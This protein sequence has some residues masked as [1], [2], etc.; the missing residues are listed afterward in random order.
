MVSQQAQLQRGGRLPP[1]PAPGPLPMRAGLGL[2]ERY[3]NAAIQEMLQRGPSAGPTGPMPGQGGEM[4]ILAFEPIGESDDEVI[5]GGELDVPHPDSHEFL[6]GRVGYDDWSLKAEAGVARAKGNGWS[7]LNAEGQAGGWY[8][9]DGHWNLGAHGHLGV[10]EGEHDFWGEP[11]E[12]DGYLRVRGGLLSMGAGQRTGTD[13][14]EGLIGFDAGYL[15]AGVGT[16][17]DAD[18]ANDLDIDLTASL[19][20]L[21]TG[22]GLNFTDRDDDGVQEL[23]L[24]LGLDIGAGVGLSVTS[25]FLGGH[26]YPWLESGRQLLGG[27]A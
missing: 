17:P 15:G 20:S 5:I 3:G 14:T 7:L 27:G 9:D 24:D 8:D 19:Y 22:L 2:Q 21:G 18:S 10:V 4:G 12:D 25:E 1:T 16:G 26:I 13:G 23:C 6:Y 11:G